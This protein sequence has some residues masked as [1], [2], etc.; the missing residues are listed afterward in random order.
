V[1]VD[2]R[3]DYDWLIVGSGFGGSVSAMRLTEKG[4]SVGMLEC[5]RR[6]EDKDFVKTTWNLWR[7]YW[8]PK[9]RMKGILR[10]TLFNDILIASGCG[11]GGGSL[12]YANTLYRPSS[13]FYQDPIWR[14]LDDWE[15]ELRPCFDTAEHMLG[16]DEYR[17]EG[18]ADELLRDLSEELGV[19]ETY[20]HTRIGVF[21]NDDAPGQ[22]VPDPYFG[23]E[24]PDRA[25]CIR[26]GA[27]MPGCRYNA[28]N[29]LPKNYLFFAERNGAQVLPERTV[30][31]VKPLGAED[32]S[33]GYAVT[34]ERSGRWLARDRQTHTARGVIVAAGPIGTN[35]LLQTCRHSGSLSRISDRLGYR[36]R[37]N[38]ESI[39]AVTVKNDRLDFTKSVAISSSIH[40]AEDTH[41]ENVTYGPGADSMALLW[42]LLVG[43]GTRITRPFKFLGQSIR[44]PINFVRANWPYKFSR[45][46]V[47]L[48][49]MQT[50]DNSMRLKAKRRLFGK[51]VKLNTEQDPENPNPTFIPVADWTVRRA[52]E[53]LDGVAQVGTTE[54]LMNVPITAHILGG[55]VMGENAGSGVIDR[56]QRVFGYENLLVCDGSAVPANPGVNPSLTITAMTEYAM[57][58]IPSREYA[59]AGAGETELAPAGLAARSNG[60]SNGSVAREGSTQ[61]G[62]APSE[63]RGPSGRA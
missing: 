43:K 3:Y 36:V 15:N 30:I 40:P 8:V 47:I 52:A 20:H 48:L 22:T 2:G 44:H 51:G 29:T 7:Y 61:T 10:L 41:I 45:R 39:P 6:F 32:G 28:K 14:D 42:T 13:A 33:D 59:A 23:G 24:G 57:S 35:Q 17:G 58:H 49:V 38:S 16:V 25:G 50:L 63:R 19:P 12:G 26:C 11:V 53:K 9:L 54:A 37:T 31:D 18:P 60:A 27:C 34:S 1:S 56:R 62:A 46:T 4:Y 21:F 55:A 5:G